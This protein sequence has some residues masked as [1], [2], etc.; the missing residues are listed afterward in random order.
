[1]P[2][3]PKGYIITDKCCD[4][5]RFY[6]TLADFPE[7]GIVSRL[8]VDRET[9]IIYVWDGSEYIT[10]DIADRFHFF[11]TSVSTYN[12]ALPLSGWTQPTPLEGATA[13]IQFAG[14]TE[15]NYTSD[16]ITWNV[17]FANIK[18]K[19]YKA[20]L[21][22][23]GTDAPVATVL[24]NTLGGTVS[25]VYNG[26]GQIEITSP[27]LFTENK[28]L[29]NITLGYSFVGFLGFINYSYRNP[30]SI[31]LVTF[32]NTI[33]ATPNNGVLDKASIT[34]EVYP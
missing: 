8:Y 12:P 17:N 19:V 33:D 2:V 20:L 1:M 4:K 10:A 21:T 13:T 6:D 7:T 28:T 27:T 30:S 24:E 11:N 23:S 32:S 9:G 34:I 29:I 14:G 16:G 25:Y 15:V 26:I 31:N 18:P 22:Q 3:I 5:T